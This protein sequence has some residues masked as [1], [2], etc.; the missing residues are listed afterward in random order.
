MIMIKRMKY[1]FSLLIG[2]V[3]SVDVAAAQDLVIDLWPDGAPTDNGLA[4]QET[5]DS[6][7][8]SLVA[9]PQ[10]W[11][12]RAENPNG[13]AI[14][15]C[16]GGGYHDVWYAHEGSNM[17]DWLKTQGISL[18]VLKYR[19]PNFHANV[20]LEDA[21]R[22]LEIV[23]QHADE[24]NCHK[25]GIAGCSAGGHLATTVATHFT[26]ERNRPDFQVLFYPVVTM[27]KGVTH[28][29][30]RY[31]LLGEKPTPELETLYSN[32]LQVTAQTPPAFILAS[33]DDNAVP[34]ENSLRYYRA[35]VANHVPVTMHLYPYGD[36]GWG[37]RDSF[38]YKPL[39]TAELAQ[40]LREL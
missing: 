30:T 36:H 17:A 26:N 15:I 18:I 8:F 24:W 33:S 23:R 10:L 16:P 20:P 12:Y 34:I 31:F 3:L 21:Q 39:W 2:I 4:G 35:L 6:E 7:H 19:M 11:L 38:A 27:E 37:F 40:W 9:H 22:A 25:V 13:K 5:G 32:E 28:E 1:L 14:V 29:G